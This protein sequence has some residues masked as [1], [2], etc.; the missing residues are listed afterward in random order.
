MSDCII[1]TTS[2]GV[3]V[4]KF[5]RPERMNA[6]GGTML[7]EFHEAILE[8]KRDDN[9]RA[10]LVTGEGRAWCAGADLQ[11]MGSG[12]PNP[13]TRRSNALD[14]EGEA[15]R[16]VRDLYSADKPTIAAVNGV[17]VG[18]GF[19]LC[20]A[21][22]IRMAGSEARFSTVFI[23]RALAPDFGLS[24]FLPRMVGMERA[25]ELFFTGRM[26]NAEESL[27]LGVVTSV[28]PQEKLMD[29]A[30]ALATTIAKQPPTALTFTRRALQ[31]AQLNT[32]EQHLRF[33][34]AHQ[35]QCL[36][37]DEFKEGVAAF[38]EKREPDYSKF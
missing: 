25:N 8:G 21:F 30:L 31:H 5:N 4:I 11:A 37:S 14:I 23:K 1:E 17:T 2:D 32:L 12:T 26:L 18:G 27:E 10:F 9:V 3:M 16:I 7:A 28:V 38:M 34:W 35:K 19:G 6:M 20:S 29:E 33:E 24:W 13:N 22:D 15:G 36:R